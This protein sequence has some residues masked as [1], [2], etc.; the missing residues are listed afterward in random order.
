MKAFGLV[1]SFDMTMIIDLKRN[2]FDILEMV[3]IHANGYIRNLE[4]K[5]GSNVIKKARQHVGPNE[6]LQIRVHS[7]KVRFQ[8]GKDRSG[9]TKISYQ[10]GCSSI[11]S[12]TLLKTNVDNKD[13]ILNY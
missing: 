7:T 13:C 3:S 1:I 10:G 4:I 9:P 11:L 6:R 8:Q 2:N 12:C 5:I